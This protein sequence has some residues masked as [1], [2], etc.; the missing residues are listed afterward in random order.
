[1]VVRILA[2]GAQEKKSPIEKKNVVQLWLTER[3]DGGGVEA[4]GPSWGL[5]FG[6]LSPG[7]LD[8]GL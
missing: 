8:P 4:V 5:K 6:L 7:L 2:F 1:L 3:K